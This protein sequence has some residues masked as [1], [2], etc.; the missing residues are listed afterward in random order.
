MTYVD[1]FLYKCWEKFLKESIERSS[2]KQDSVFAASQIEG[3][4]ERKL[5]GQ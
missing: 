3:I 1:N 2:F 5:Y 4:I